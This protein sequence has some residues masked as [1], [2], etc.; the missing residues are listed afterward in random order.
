VFTRRRIAEMAF[1]SLGRP[2]KVI[3]V[4][5]AA[6]APVVAGLRLAHRR[7]AGIVEFGIE[8]SRLDCVAPAYG[9]RRLGE[10]L[11]AARE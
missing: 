5:R 8:V 6:F 2:P 11:R 1:E 10:Y 4:P 7:L 3:G 9:I